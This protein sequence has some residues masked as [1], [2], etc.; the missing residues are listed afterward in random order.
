MGEQADPNWFPPLEQALREPPGLLAA[1]G[2]LRPARLLAAYER[3]VFPWYSAQQPILWWSPDPRMVLFPEEFSCSRSLRKTLRNG[4][5]T[6]E[7]DHAFGATIR[8]CAAPRRAGPETWLND[9]HD[10]LLRRAV[11]ARVRSLGRNL[12]CRP[13]GGRSV[14]HTARPGLLRRIDVQPSAAMRP[15][16]RSRAWSRSAAHATFGS[17]TAR[18]RVPTWHPWALAR[19]PAPSL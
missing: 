2:D 17:S 6:T 13:P 12:R 14:R 15:R 9:D 4:P 16:W 3:G 5:Y 7:V 10:R 18:W 1:G 11:R 19:S 8:A